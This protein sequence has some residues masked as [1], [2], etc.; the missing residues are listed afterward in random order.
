MLNTQP[1]NF[2]SRIVNMMMK[3]KIDIKMMSMK[4]MMMMSLQYVMRIMSP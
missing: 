2:I 4:R 3:M 1:N